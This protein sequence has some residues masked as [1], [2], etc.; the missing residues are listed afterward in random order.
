MTAYAIEDLDSRTDR[1]LPPASY[2]DFDRPNLS[3]VAVGK[4]DD[5]TENPGEY[6]VFV[7]GNRH[8]MVDF[9]RFITWLS[10]SRTATPLEMSMPPL[11]GEFETAIGKF[12]AG[13]G[14]ACPDDSV[15]MAARAI[16][17]VAVRRT[18]DPEVAVDD[19]DGALSFDLR[20]PDGRLVLAELCPDGQLHVGVYDKDDQLLEHRTTGYEY[21]VSVIES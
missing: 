14:G 18:S 3:I 15:V 21:L 16:W 1:W 7:A 9:E 13:M 6:K 4:N 11:S 10:D 19:V 5:A 12:E 17:Q 20:L 2:R 8:N